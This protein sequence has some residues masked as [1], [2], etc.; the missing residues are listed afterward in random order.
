[1]TEHS[2]RSPVISLNIQRYDG[3]R[4]SCKHFSP[5]VKYCL[6]T[7][8][9]LLICRVLMIKIVCHDSNTE[10]K[11]TIFVFVKALKSLSKNELDFV[12]NRR[13]KPKNSSPK[14]CI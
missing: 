9:Q 1:M 5:L 11:N 3:I 8:L 12:E 6:N 14:R 10:D 13:K 7:P 4:H 2:P